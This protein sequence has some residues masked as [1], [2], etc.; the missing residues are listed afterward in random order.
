MKTLNPGRWDK[1]SEKNMSK[2][3]IL[4]VLS[5][6]SVADYHHWIRNR[7]E[8]NPRWQEGREGLAWS[9]IILL[10]DDLIKN[11][12]ASVVCE[13]GYDAAFFLPS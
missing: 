7:C 11:S 2:T 3:P 12:P 1:Q 4:V 10:L 6:S 9:R 13:S 5:L 8:K